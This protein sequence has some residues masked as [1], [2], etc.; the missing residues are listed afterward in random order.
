MNKS[1]FPGWD[2][3]PFR[4]NSF[5]PSVL[6]LLYFTPEIRCAVESHQHELFQYGK[7]AKLT[8][9]RDLG[10]SYFLFM[11]KFKFAFSSCFIFF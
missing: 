5:F 1:V 6:L 2:Y 9:M 10:K 4:P 11:T 3:A 7:N 8:E